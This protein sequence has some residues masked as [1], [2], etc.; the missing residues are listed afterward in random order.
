MLGSFA[1]LAADQAVDPDDGDPIWDF[2]AGDEPF[3]GLLAVESLGAGYRCETWL[4]WLR[5]GW[6]PAVL[7]LPRP[8]QQDHPR[9]RAALGRELAGLRAGAGHPTFP[10]LISDH[11]GEETPY[12][13]MEYVDGPS[14]AEVV[15]EQGALEATDA[16]LLG[17]ALLPALLVLHESGLAHVDV[18]SENVL[19]LDGRPFLVDFGSARELGR[20]QPSGHPV[21]TTGYAA[22]EMEACEPI[23]ASMDLYGL[24]TVLAEALTGKPFPEG[25][26]LPA[27]PVTPLVERLLDPDPARRGAP[28]EILRELA[29]SVPDDRRPWPEWVD[30]HLPGAGGSR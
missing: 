17:V 16:A 29:H 23:A 24:G 15:D 22:P 26:P 14:L 21:G 2:A 28:P 8:H 30:A 11:I 9:A 1:G 18:K 10:R 27:G 4:V 25:A 3:P 6:H 20:P 19:L 13:V 7:K 5:A 12:L